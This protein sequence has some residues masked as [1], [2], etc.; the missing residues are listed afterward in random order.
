MNLKLLFLAL[1][2]LLLSGLNAFTFYSPT[3]RAEY[4]RVEEGNASWK[5]KEAP[6]I[7]NSEKVVRDSLSLARDIDYHINYQTGEFKVLGEIPENTLIEIQYQVYPTNLLQKFYTYQ[8]IDYSDTL[9]IKKAKNRNPFLS[10]G[11]KINLTGSKTISI[12]VANNED[13]DLKQSL[14]LKLDGELGPNM[15][16]EA[17]LSDSQSPITPE[18]DSRELS[19]LDQVFIRLYG[20]QYEVAFGDLDM[21][22]SNTRL[23]DYT[24]KFEGLKVT[25]SEKNS[26]QT[27]YA[28]SKGK[29]ADMTFQGV[30]GKQGPYYL[31]VADNPEGVLVVP[32]T[33]DVYL[34]GIQLQRGSD[35]T[36]DY[37]EGSIT[38]KLLITSNSS[39]TV[40][41]QYTDNFYRQSLF[42]N[43]SSWKITDKMTLS[44]HLIIQTDDKRNPLESSLTPDDVHA[45]QQSGDHNAHGKGIFQVKR[46]EGLYIAA[47]TESPDTLSAERDVI[48]IYVGPN[49]NGDY[50]IY[51]TYVG[52]G[53]GDYSQ[54]APSQYLW[55]GKN[56]GDWMP[57]KDLPA[58][59][60][61]ANYDLQFS[62]NADIWTYDMEGLMTNYDQNTFS[63][64]DDGDNTGFVGHINLQIKPDYDKLNPIIESYY[65][66]KSA[67]VKAFGALTDAQDSYDLIQLPSSDSL[68]SDEW[69]SKLQL[70]LFKIFTPQLRYRY[71]SVEHYSIQKL[72]SFTADLKQ[73]WLI[74]ETYYRIMYVKQ[75]FDNNTLLKSMIS[76]QDFREIHKLKFIH[77][78]SQFQRY[79]Y[80]NEYKHE[81]NS[82]TLLSQSSYSAGLDNTK[83]YT[84]SFSYGKDKNSIMDTRGNQ[85]NEQKNSSTYTLNQFLNTTNHTFKVDF[86]H[87]QTHSKL[88]GEQDQK[89]DLIEMH[90]THDFLSH[91]FKGSTNYKVNNLEFYPKVR[92]LVYVGNDLGSYD[93]TGVYVTHG[94]YDYDVVNVGTTELSTEV[95]SDVTLF[96][97]PTDIPGFDKK[98]FLSR[99]Q[100]ESYALVNENSRSSAKSNIYLMNPEYLMNRNTTIYG[101]QIFRQT[102]WYDLVPRIS[103]TKVKYQRER[104]LDNRYDENSWNSKVI[105]EGMLRYNK[106]IGADWELTGDWNHELDS[107]YKSDIKTQDM[108]LDIRQKQSNQLILETTL[109]YKME[110]GT[111]VGSSTPYS[112]KGF[113]AAESVTYFWR[114]NYRIYSKFDVRR[115]QR[116]GSSYL[117]FLPEKRQG[118]VFLWNLSVNYKL[119]SF[120]TAMLDYSGNQYPN[121]PAIHK[122]TMELR[123]EF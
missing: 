112:L 61:I 89:Y 83:K 42:L 4:L 60:S 95:N 32:G 76:R 91:S 116:T 92:K 119:N 69:G 73:K 111:Q 102:L 48:Y 31:S 8:I 98:N 121:Q 122:A 7:V 25:Y 117:S 97:S 13:F 47:Y 123:A 78:G 24:A 41:F 113:G 6:I 35:Y 62:Y 108:E 75:D 110:D 84:A 120:T 105:W 59:Q 16:I 1:L 65:R 37:S 20:K 103:L 55:V 26:I 90:T 27:A 109:S 14:F 38:F 36:I 81:V 94:D 85:W 67:N 28:L 100:S 9:A 63:S 30:E 22:F 51:F 115:N 45:L 70:T 80:R 74:P 19:S 71:Q 66:R 107:R 114:Q 93:S 39:I 3:I 68:A 50:L 15:K 23:I 40:H 72:G 49:K 87:R 104:S 57:W 79:E 34:D 106:L 46:G 64:K 77:F 21:K 29:K 5:L 99:M 17:Q 88:E 86:T 43:S 44:D 11:E 10:N 52:S 56:K 118:M 82:G 2:T 96:I 33:E 53:K 12:S 101:K 54:V 58:P 18:G